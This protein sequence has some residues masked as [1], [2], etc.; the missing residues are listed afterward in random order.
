MEEQVVRVG[1]GFD[2]HK[3]GKPTTDPKKNKILLCGTKIPCEYSIIGHSDG[4]LVFHALTDALLGALGKGDIGDHF[5]PT[6]PKWKNA[7]SE[8]FL[9]FALD[10]LKQEGG[11]IN[12]VD[13]T[14]IAETPKIS[15]FKEEFT[16]KIST[17]L[18]IRPDQINI[19]AKTAEQMGAI[20]RKEGLA[21]QAI[22][23]LAIPILM[24][25]L[26]EN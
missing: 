13:V 22:V 23:S 5:P 16:K 6:D 11:S 1:L 20:G 14:I 15:P 19:K 25:Q 9:L 4:D 2:S 8:K 7:N 18:S 21:C 17:T 10:I 3:F 24:R 26:E 12:N